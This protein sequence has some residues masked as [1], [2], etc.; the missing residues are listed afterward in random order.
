M[1]KIVKQEEET[2]IVIEKL[3]AENKKMK[4]ELIFKYFW[5]K[6]PQNK[7]GSEPS[8]EDNSDESIPKEDT[9]EC[10]VTMQ[11]KGNCEHLSCRMQKMQVQGGRRTS[12]GTS[13]ILMNTCP[14]CG[15]SV[16]TKN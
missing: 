8:H 7:G 12:P 4:T 5:F 3:E 6:N 16:S 11:C 13:P 2:Q 1:K 15:F 9:D 14:Q 10:I